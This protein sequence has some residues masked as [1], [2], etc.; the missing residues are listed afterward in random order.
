MP[1]EGASVSNNAKGSISGPP[2][3]D[4]AKFDFNSQTTV[5]IIKMNY[6]YSK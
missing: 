5:L 1:T 4:A 3:F 6:Q 2:T